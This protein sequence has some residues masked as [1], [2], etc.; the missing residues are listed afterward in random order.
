MKKKEKDHPFIAEV[1]SPH[2]E[3]GKM[4]VCSCGAE[5]IVVDQWEEH[6]EYDCVTLSMWQNWTG[7]YGW[8]FQLQ[9]IWYI[10]KHGHPYA[11]NICLSRSQVKKMG[12]LFTKLSKNKSKKKKKED[13]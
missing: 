6:D 2:T 8:R 10:I 4:Y 1:D 9:Q 13:K 5:A 11:D 12:T 7:N 3:A